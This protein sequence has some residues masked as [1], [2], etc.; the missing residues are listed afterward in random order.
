MMQEPRGKRDVL[1]FTPRTCGTGD[2]ADGFM[3]FLQSLPHARVELHTSILIS[4]SPPLF[5]TCV[6]Q[7]Q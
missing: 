1:G 4:L 5:H 3:R 7:G 2:R 6:G